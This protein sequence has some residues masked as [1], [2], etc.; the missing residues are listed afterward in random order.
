MT[1]MEATVTGNLFTN[2]SPQYRNMPLVRAETV[3]RAAETVRR[4]AIA[5]LCAPRVIADPES[6]RVE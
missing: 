1:M 4:V 5:P 6:T 3:R 2:C